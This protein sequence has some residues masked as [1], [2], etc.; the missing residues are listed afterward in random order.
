MIGTLIFDVMI[1]MKLIYAKRAPANPVI[2][3]SQSVIGFV[4][5]SSFKKCLLTRLIGS[6]NP[7]RKCQPELM[8]SKR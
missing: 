6:E 7:R 2:I 3:A 8:N 5:A 4:L 1:L